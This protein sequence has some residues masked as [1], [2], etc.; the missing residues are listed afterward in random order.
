MNSQRKTSRKR[1]SGRF[2]KRVAGYAAAAGALL[3]TT[4]NTNA[5]VVVW[6]PD[7]DASIGGG[8]G[9]LY[10]RMLNGQVN[11]LA[12]D[13]YLFNRSYATYQRYKTNS[14]CYPL[15][16]G[17]GSRCYPVY[18]TRAYR[19]H[20]A[21]VG[22]AASSNA[23]QGTG[24]RGVAKLY[25]GSLIGGSQ[26]FPLS[27]LQFGVAKQ[28]PGGGSSSYGN[29]PR[30]N[31]GFIGLR[32]RDGS[33]THYGWAQVRR[34][35]DFSLTLKRFAYETELGRPITAGKT[36]DIPLAAI[37]IGQENGDVVVRFS[38]NNGWIYRLQR[39][40]ALSDDQWTDV[41]DVTA[42]SDGPNAI[43]HVGGAGQQEAYYRVVLVVP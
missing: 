43:T 10:F 9:Q 36:A 39:K 20:Y 29:W 40:A 32:F 13:F 18:S 26:N 12:P 11:G 21:Y 7:P 22:P 38:G 37:G 33:D 35:D 24:G 17:T 16:T 19:R 4:P 27:N 34:E 28:F 2:E 5:E 14:I 3:A 15:S 41:T 31:E 1:R 42:S 8:N 25:S 6:D 30:N 23:V